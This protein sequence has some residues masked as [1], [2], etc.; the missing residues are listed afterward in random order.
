[1]GREETAIFE[2]RTYAVAGFFDRRIGET[3]DG[4]MMHA[5]IEGIDFHFDKFA[6]ESERGGGK[7]LGRHTGE[8]LVGNR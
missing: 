2:S 4:E 8:R 5:G 3:D 6:F 7:Y 1:M